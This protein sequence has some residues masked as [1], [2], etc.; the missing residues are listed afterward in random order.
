MLVL[1]ISD[2]VILG[3]VPNIPEPQEQRRSEIG[4][5]TFPY[6]M[7]LIL[8]RPSSVAEQMRKHIIWNVDVF[9][10]LNILH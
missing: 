4:Q 1:H 8:V 7:N 2:Y 10:R 6:L 9:M 3:M 5:S